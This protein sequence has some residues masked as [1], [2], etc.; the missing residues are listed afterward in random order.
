M[1][2]KNSAFANDWAQKRK[3]AVEKA[4]L[5]KQ[6]RERIKEENEQN[7]ENE[8]ENNYNDYNN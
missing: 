7:L 1:K 8:K 5:I 6:N 4:K 2:S 3:E